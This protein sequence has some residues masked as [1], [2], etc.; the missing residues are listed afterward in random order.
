ML[1]NDRASITPVQSHL[2]QSMAQRAA[3][4]SF[5]SGNRRSSKAFL[6]RVPKSWPAAHCTAAPASFFLY[7]KFS[8]ALSTSTRKSGSSFLIGGRG[9]RP[10]LCVTGGKRSYRVCRFVARRIRRARL[11]LARRPAPSFFARTEKTI[12]A[13]TS[14]PINTLPPAGRTRRRM[15]SWRSSAPLQRGDNQIVSPIGLRFFPRSRN[16]FTDCLFFILRDHYNYAAVPNFVLIHWRPSQFRR[17]RFFLSHG[18][19]SGTDANILYLTS[20]CCD[21]EQK[22]EPK[23]LRAMPESINA[24]RT[25][26]AGVVRVVNRAINHS[27]RVF[28]DLHDQAT[29]GQFVSPQ[30]SFASLPDVHC[31]HPI[32]A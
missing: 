18:D 19:T 3:E 32:P 12:N 5:A 13:K 15:V 2:L 8:S 10:F 24:A 9:T 11:R 29:S 7:C 27:A 28:A 14:Q 21:I 16:S 20:K 31:R 23:R 1:L 22:C 25:I 30:M 26:P 4:P 6:S 17:F